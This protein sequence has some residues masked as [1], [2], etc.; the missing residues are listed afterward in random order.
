MDGSSIPI[1]NQPAKNAS[2]ITKDP[3]QAAVFPAEPLTI[4]LD[5][6]LSQFSWLEK[7]LVMAELS[8]L[9]YGPPDLISK[10]VYQAGIDQCDFV[11]QAGS[12]AFVFGTPYDCLIVSRGTEPTKW[13]DI[14]ADAKAWTIACDIGRVHSGFDGH[15]NLLW[16]ELENRLKEN[17]R[18][19]WFAGHSLGG[20]PS[21]RFATIVGSITTML[22]LESL[23]D[24]WGTTIWDAKSMSTGKAK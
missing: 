12:E 11:A 24:S 15:V 19:V 16:P 13:E 2:G 17:Q 5:R 10:V 21:S 7:S 6:Q 9:A 1:N 3:K 8:R 20:H 4:K 18:S 22:S 14:A 23:H